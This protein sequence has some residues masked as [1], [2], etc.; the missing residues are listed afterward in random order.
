MHKVHS[1][2]EKVSKNLNNLLLCGVWSN[3]FDILFKSSYEPENI[4]V[5]CWRGNFKLFPLD[6]AQPGAYAE[7]N[8]LSQAHSLRGGLVYCRNWR[9]SYMRR[10]SRCGGLSC[11]ARVVVGGSRKRAACVTRLSARSTGI[12]AETVS[13]AGSVTCKLTR[14]LTTWSTLSSGTADAAAWR[15]SMLLRVG[16]RADVRWLSTSLLSSCVRSNI[17]LFYE[18]GAKRETR[19]STTSSPAGGGLFK[20][21]VR[22]RYRRKK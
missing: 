11:T 21:V 10:I 1:I 2:G 16:R 3:F 13:A 7:S 17:C 4:L 19:L 14:A 15:A 12:E 18:R 8:V 5:D 22:R 6:F 9:P 20:T